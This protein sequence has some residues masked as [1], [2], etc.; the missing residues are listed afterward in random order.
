MATKQFRIRKEAPPAN[1]RPKAEPGRI[2]REVARMKL[3]PGEWFKVRERAAAGSQRVYQQR[4]CETRTVSVG[5]GRHDIYA[6]FIKDEHG[7]D[8]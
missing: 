5:E 3:E 7:T 8:G 4:G 2:D 6:R 1:T